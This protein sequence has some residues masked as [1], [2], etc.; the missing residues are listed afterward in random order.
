MR[1]EPNQV[2]CLLIQK[3]QHFLQ[4]LNKTQG[5]KTTF[6]C[7]QYNPKLLSIQRSRKNPNSHGKRQPRDTKAKMTQ[8]LEVYDK[9]FK[10]TS[11]KNTPGSKSKYSK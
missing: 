5:L 2:D 6:K 4:D 3:H 10:E 8:M 7:L 1:L 9:D 11:T